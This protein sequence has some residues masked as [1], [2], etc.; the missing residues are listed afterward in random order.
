MEVVDSTDPMRLVRE[1]KC[2]LIIARQ[3]TPDPDLKVEPLFCEQLLVVAG[4]RSKWASRRK[5]AL[6][7][8][9]DETWIQARHEVVPG[10]PTFEAFRRCGL[11]VPGVRVF[12]N[13]LNL[14]YSLLAKG[15]F[16]TMI[17][18]SV[19]R[20]SP[21]RKLVK[22]LPVQVP[23]WHLPYGIVTLRDR[24][25]SP[26]AELFIGCLRELAGPLAKSR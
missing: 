13:S 24:T 22:V 25:L 1:R 9:V 15:R 17:P 10:A 8:L 4:P 26:M 5:I 23:R 12:S 14:R 18:A 3:L 11:D 16:L 2:E 20:F 19:L 7:Q 6:A 21:G